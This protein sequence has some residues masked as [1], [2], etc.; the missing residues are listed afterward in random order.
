[1]EGVPEMRPA[2]AL[3]ASV[4]T[5]KEPATRR[6]EDNCW[7]MGRKDVRDVFMKGKIDKCY[8]YA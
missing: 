3:G 1:M 8:F 4:S 7:R 5:A 6:R 2:N